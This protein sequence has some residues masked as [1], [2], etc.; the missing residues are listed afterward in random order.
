MSILLARLLS[1]LLQRQFEDERCTFA[2]SLAVNTERAA[3]LLSTQNAAVQTKTVAVFFGCET[4]TKDLVEVFRF[5]PLSSIAHLDMGK[6]RLPCHL[7]NPNGQTIRDVS[8]PLRLSLGILLGFSLGFLH[9]LFGIA[10]QVHNAQ[11]V[12]P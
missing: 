10:D 6:V 4:L 8:I 3:H 2:F 1:D 7:S 9:R 5:D 12:Y 11:R